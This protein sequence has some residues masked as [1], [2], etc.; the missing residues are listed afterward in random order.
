MSNSLN[1]CNSLLHRSV[2]DDCNFQVK[3]ISRLGGTTSNEVVKRLLRRLLSDGIAKL[4]SYHG[5]KQ[6]LP[7]SSLRIKNVIFGEMID[8]YAMTMYNRKIK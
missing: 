7:F 8:V 2:Q 6:K 5:F 4:Y 3:E 1:M